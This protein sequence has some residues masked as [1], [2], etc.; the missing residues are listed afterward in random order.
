MTPR[1]TNEPAVLHYAS[2]TQNANAQPPLYSCPCGYE[3][4]EKREFV[5]LAA[6][7]TCAWRARVRL[8]DDEEEAVT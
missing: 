5:P 8:V 7:V 2:L 3:S 6:R 4:T 1:R